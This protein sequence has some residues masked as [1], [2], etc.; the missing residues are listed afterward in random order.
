VAYG[1]SHFVRVSAHPFDVRKADVP[2]EVSDG[3][4]VF[5]MRGIFI[6]IELMVEMTKVR[7]ATWNSPW[8]GVISRPGGRQEAR[9]EEQAT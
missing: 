9:A 1:T 2:I 6:R 5:R 4:R 3:R 8:V 7:E